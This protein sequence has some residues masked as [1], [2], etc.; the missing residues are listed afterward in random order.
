MQP[1][2]VVL[3]G[4]GNVASRIAPLINASPDF[5]IIAVASRN[6]DHARNL[7]QALGEDVAWTDDFSSVSST[8]ADIVLISVADNAIDTV[9]GAIGRLSSQPLVLH[10]SGTLDR[11]LLSP[12]SSRTGVLYPLQTFSKGRVIDMTGVPIFTEAE[13]PEDHAVVD[14]MA[15]AISSKVE[16]TSPTQRKGLHIAGVMT[17]NFTNVLLEE[18]QKILSEEG[19]SL[20]V[21]RPLIEETV[22]KAFAVGPHDAQTGPAR[23]GDKEVIAEHINRLPERLKGIYAGLSDLIYKSHH[24]QDTI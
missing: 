13:V 7:A 12:I 19:Y 6:A 15:G 23:R 3:I 11:A 14:V 21:V 1:L 24:E 22:A 8:S 10:T 5:Q 18:V 9:V 17:N 4:T 2:K 16:H 20:D